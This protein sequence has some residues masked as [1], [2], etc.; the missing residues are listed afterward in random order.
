MRFQIR[1]EKR[2]DWADTHPEQWAAY[3]AAIREAAR[4]TADAIDRE[5][6]ER[7]ETQA[8]QVRRCG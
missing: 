6:A 5:L 8:Q 3:Q 2:P 7:M 1:G 4:R